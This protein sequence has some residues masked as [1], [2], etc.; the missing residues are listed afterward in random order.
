[1]NGRTILENILDKWLDQAMKGYQWKD[2]NERIPMKNKNNTTMKIYLQGF[3]QTLRL[4]RRLKT[5]QFC[6]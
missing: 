4:Q 5:F 2:T 3:P 1:M 6:Q